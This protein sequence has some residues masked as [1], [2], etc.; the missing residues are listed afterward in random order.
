[1]EIQ[2]NID[3]LSRDDADVVTKVHWRLSGTHNGR[4]EDVTG[5]VDLEP[6]GESFTPY[7]DLTRSEV[8]SWFIH[9]FGGTLSSAESI[10]INKLNYQ[11][12]EIKANPPW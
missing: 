9:R 12:D 1:M 6:P 3:S 10:L 7:E 8:V 2:F 4:T 11:P 5:T